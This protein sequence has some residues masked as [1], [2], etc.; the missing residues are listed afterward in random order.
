MKKL[1]TLV[2]V[3]FLAVSLFS[4]GKSN[5][6]ELALITD[7][8]TIDDKS[9]NQGSWEGLKKYAEEKKLSY[10]YYQPAEVSTDSY[11]ATIELAIKGGAKVVVT[12]GFLFENAIYLAQKKY[13][14][15]HF[16]LIDGCPN[17]ATGWD[18]EG[19]PILLAGESEYSNE[20]KSNT[21]SIFYAEEQSGFLAGY[22]AVK[23]GYRKLGFMGG[24]AVPAVVK[25]GIGFVQ[26][27]NYAAEELKLT[28]KL[29][30]KYHY[31]G[32]FNASPEIQSKA[33]GWYTSGTE[34]V[35]ACGGAVGN[36]VFKA[37][38]SLDG[39]YAIGVDVDQSKDSSRVITSAMKM[40]GTSVYDTIAAYYNGKFPG[41]KS[42]VLAA[43]VGGVGLP[44]DNSKF[45][46]FSKADYDAILAKLVDGSVTVVKTIEDGKDV[47]NFTTL[48]KVTVVLE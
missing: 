19:K 30:I 17:N 7:K 26:G 42:S 39:K 28:E 10:K 36:S 24:M 15:V 45:K 40:L 3:M 5:T 35:F 21:A 44:M 6:Y 20:V 16:I 38:E 11:F 47:T 18:S 34:V 2:F 27:A 29:D 43:N 46:T 13:P 41:G 37:A 33:S 8:G 1:L 48:N 32:G 14:E 23:D 9:F 12:P 4:C 31:T 25:F 22:A